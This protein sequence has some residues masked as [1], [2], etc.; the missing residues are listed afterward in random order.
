MLVRLLAALWLLALSA[1]ACAGTLTL[2]SAEQSG[3]RLRLG[4]H[5]V[6]AEPLLEALDAGVPLVFELRIR[7]AEN[8]ATHSIRMNYVPALERY[9]LTT[10]EKTQSFRLRVEMLDAFGALSFLAVPGANKV[11]LHLSFAE[12][13]APLRMPAMLDGAWWLDSGWATLTSSP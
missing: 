10:P 11:R 3:G 9:E 12:L 5:C 2:N 8:A 4:V 7:G 6:L 13:P 1:A